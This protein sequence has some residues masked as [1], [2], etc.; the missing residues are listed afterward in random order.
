[1]GDSEDDE[2]GR[3]HVDVT[4]QFEGRSIESE[5]QEVGYQMQQNV[6]F[7]DTDT[8]VAENVAVPN[9]ETPVVVSDQGNIQDE[10]EPGASRCMSDITGSVSCVESDEDISIAGRVNEGIGRLLGYTEENHHDEHYDQ[11]QE[12]A[13][14]I[15]GYEI[16]GTERD[17]F[18]VYKIR[19]SLPSSVFGAWYTTRR[20][21]DFLRL[22][23]AL[24]KEHPALESQLPFPP[25]RW[26]GS[27]L[28]P[29]FLGRRLA[30]LQ[31]FLVSVLEIKALLSNQ[32]VRSFLCLDKT[33]SG[34]ST[35][36]ENRVICDTLEE[37][38]KE[39]RM[40]LRKK[41]RL[42]QELDYHKQMNFEKD[43]QIQNLVKETKM[44]RKQL[45]VLDN[46]D[47]SGYIR[48]NHIG[49]LEN[50]EN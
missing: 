10:E 47:R 42:E 46:P 29:T 38:V 22:R 23:N 27:N 36:Q 34:Q 41:E 19:V 11:L 25:K 7:E 8:V 49:G 35:F 43:R 3:E 31:F 9:P 32:V 45:K 40:Q 30:G 50:N 5:L 14:Q 16:V 4:K 6:A 37:T 13:A 33:N 17:R 1:V 18:T 28:E 26:I 12:A 24:V 20:Y 15:L 44:L 48:E 39:L 2:E 21:S